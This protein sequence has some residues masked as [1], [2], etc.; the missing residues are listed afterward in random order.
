MIFSTKEEY[1]EVFEEFYNPLCNFANKIVERRDLAED[2]VQ[3]VFVQIWQKRE[4]IN[5]KTSLKNYLFQSTRNKAIEILRRKKLETK[6]INSEM[7]TMET[8]YNIE[9]DADAYMLKDK[10]KRCIRQLPPK[11]QQI[12]VMSKMNGLTYAEIAEELNLSVKTVENQ[13]GRGLKLLRE[14]LTKMRSDNANK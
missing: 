1:K 6:Y 12:F 2:V 13:I 10:L 14:M 9:S 3:E 8:S 7:N 4:S 5:L 11:C